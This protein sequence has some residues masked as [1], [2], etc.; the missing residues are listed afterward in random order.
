MSKFFTLMAALMLLC[1]N[2]LHAQDYVIKMKTAH[3]VG[4]WMGFSIQSNGDPVDIIGAEYVD[5]DFK[6]TAQEIELRG[7]ITR[8]DCSSNWLESIDVSGDPLL[9]ELYCDNNRLTQVTL[10][11]Q[12]NLTDLYVG[13][14]QLTSIDLSGL[15]ALKSI[16][17]YKNSLTTIDVSHNPN[18]KEIVCRENSLQGTLDLSANPLVERVACY[19]NGLT[20]IK[21]ATNNC[22]GK[23]EIERNNINGENMTAL[24]KSLPQYKEL[25]DY[26]DWYGMDPQGFYPLEYSSSLERNELTKSDLS[27][28]KAKGW[29][30]YAVDNVDD[31]EGLK[32]VDDT[33]TGIKSVGE[34][35]SDN[36]NAPACI[37]DT[38]GR[39]VSARNAHGGIYIIKK[40][41]QASKV[42]VR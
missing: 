30:V 14:N 42:L 25:E 35:E 6:V 5:G 9:V 27:I 40:G 26:E 37:Y 1:G 28:L 8:L 11:N 12:P 36:S 31:F 16:S 18:L 3:A 33:M 34:N 22:V 24:V 10:G 41:N 17:C 4:E 13:D 7:N 29:P 20:F 32:E 23:M 21:L 38:T 15:S 19:N 39:R 2:A